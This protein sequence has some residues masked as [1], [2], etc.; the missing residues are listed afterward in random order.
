MVLYRILADLIV[1]AHATYVAFVVFGLVAIV[2]GL[3]WR[4]S[5]AR[6]FWFR[7]LHLAAIAY[8][9]FEEAAGIP[10][11]LTHWENQLRGLAGQATY[12]GDFL[13]YWAHTLIFFDL[14]PQFFTAVYVTFGLTVVAVFVLGPPRGPRWGTR[15]EQ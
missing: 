14:P 12:P 15:R 1:I 11:P 13:G 8:V 3:I 10:C 9:V 6:N 7:M 4:R 2:L 5:W